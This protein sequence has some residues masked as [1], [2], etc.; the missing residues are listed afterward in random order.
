MGDASEN[1]DLQGYISQLNTSCT[2]AALTRLWYSCDS[3]NFLWLQ[4]ERLKP[5]NGIEHA[6][7]SHLIGADTVKRALPS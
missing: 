2:V 7:A 6:Y 5:A 4:R 1:V 3:K